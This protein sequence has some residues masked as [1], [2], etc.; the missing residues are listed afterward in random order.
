MDTLA[1]AAGTPHPLDDALR[2]DPDGD[3]FA[4]RT[5][6]AYA[7][8]VGPFGGAI[9]ATMLAAVLR[10]PARAG[11]PIALTVNFSGPIADGGFRVNARPVRTT[12]STQHWYAELVQ[13]D[14]VATSATAVLATRRETWSSTEID[15]PAVPPAASIARLPPL[16]RA[17]WTN[18]YDM[19][20]VHGAPTGRAHAP[21]DPGSESC[22]WVRDEPPRPLDFASLAAISDVFFPR[23]FLRRPKWVPVGTVSLT[24][25]F[26]ADAAMLAAQG[27][28]AVLGTA[29]SNR[30]GAGYFDQSAEL[31]GDDGALLATSHQVVYYKE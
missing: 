18:R 28:R 10:H 9:A 20:F 1:P 25:F 16:E 30:F 4:G 8:M 14:R 12:R 31:W 22:L 17:E 26:H 23:L 29:R 5:T 13:G 15:F 19:R 27:E 7:N 3:G 11:D 2:L 6:P 24:T 21:A